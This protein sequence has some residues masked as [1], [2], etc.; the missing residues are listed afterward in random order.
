[1]NVII[2]KPIQGGAVR[3]IASKSEAHRLLICAALSD[4]ETFENCAERSQDIDA[5][6]RCLEVLGAA[7]RYDGNGF[8]VKPLRRDLVSPGAE[9]RMLDC[10]ESGSTL[11]FILPVCGALGKSVAFRMGG[12]LPERPLSGLC[13][14]MADHGCKLSKPGGS[15]L[16][17]DGHL[18]SGAYA[19]PGDVSSQFVSGLLFA[20]PLLA[21]DSLL[22]VTGA[23]ESR[24]YVD[25]TLETLRQFG[26]RISESGSNVFN[27]PGNQSFRS[28][29]SVSASGDWSNAA[30]W[31]AAGALGQN[32]VNCANLNL[33][34]KQ[35]DRAVVDLLSRFG[36]RVVCGKNSVT[37]SAGALRGMVI[38][39]VNTPDL[40]PVLSAVASVSMGRTVIKGAGRLRVK[41]S[42]RLRTVAASLSS[43]GADVT[44]TG[45]GLTINGKKE[46]TGGETES[47]GDHRIAM[48][49]AIIKAKCREPVRIKNAEAVNK[50]YPGFWADF[51]TFLAGEWEEY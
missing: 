22:R 13:G 48:S 39:A 21:G 23:L 7:V 18:L 49:A 27:I 26:I 36:A 9:R 1:V 20:L 10:G 38:D 8:F 19:L 47:F 6:A 37:V 2:T 29:K 33:E 12:R 31:L 28:P 3:A 34:S 35:G 4:G 46:L 50:S 5:T 25:M 42:D 41:E 24:P 15:T 30:F 16:I 45:D 11:R 14:E 40:V 32:G 44:E 17:C 43:L 51:K